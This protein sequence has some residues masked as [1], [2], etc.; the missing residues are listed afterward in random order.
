[1][2]KYAVIFMG[3]IAANAIL[4]VGVPLLHAYATLSVY[5]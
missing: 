2:T 4:F 3:G 5:V 1:M